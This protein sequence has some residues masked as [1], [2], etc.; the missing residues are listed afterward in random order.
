ML[1]VLPCFALIASHSEELAS[2][3]EL[4]GRR[5]DSW[6]RDDLQPVVAKCRLLAEQLRF[7]PCQRSGADLDRALRTLQRALIAE[8]QC[9]A[10]PSL[11]SLIERLADSR[12]HELDL[13]ATGDS[14]RLLVEN[15]FFAVK[16]R[17][18]AHH[19]TSSW[20]LYLQRMGE[21]LEDCLEE[22]TSATMTAQSLQALRPLLEGSW[23]RELEESYKTGPTRWATLNMTLQA[24]RAYLA[25][26]SEDDLLEVVL[27]HLLDSLDELENSAGQLVRRLGE[28][29]ESGSEHGRSQTQQLLRE[30][31]CLS[32]NSLRIL[33]L[34]EQGQ[35][36]AAA[37]QRWESQ[38]G[39]M[40]A[41]LGSF[42]QA[43]DAV[44]LLPC[45]R[46]ST[47]NPPG[48]RSCQGCGATLP[49]SA[50]VGE[51][52]GSWT[53]S[54]ADPQDA[55]GERLRPLILAID[56]AVLEP[57]RLPLVSPLVAELWNRLSLALQQKH[58]LPAPMLEILE[59]LERAIEELEAQRLPQGR[60]LLLDA[61]NRA[62][63]FISW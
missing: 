37:W 55:L 58:Q 50:Y 16:L 54:E 30:L 34:L 2:G 20:P 8:P 31:H 3:L 25:G 57:R 11:P 5:L 38:L 23:R 19:H 26:Q 12:P 53:L 17:L 7:D 18:Q 60:R 29:Q 46:C 22:R 42:L 35:D 39:A 49:R 62:S 56:E 14:V 32:Q 36:V 6:D 33:H 15:E 40:D 24:G 41:G 10:W 61:Q 13:F 47:L 4:L 1:D 45:P 51:R 21:C 27:N 28:L 44:G 9:P 43:C 59:L 63:Q 52:Q 48:R